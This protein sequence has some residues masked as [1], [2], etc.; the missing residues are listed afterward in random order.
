[1]VL[2]FF[3]IAR[4]DFDARTMCVCVWM[5]GCKRP[6][7]KIALGNLIKRL[8]LWL[9]ME[10]AAVATDEAIDEPNCHITRNGK[11]KNQIVFLGWHPANGRKVRTRKSVIQSNA[12][13]DFSA[14]SQM[15]FSGWPKIAACHNVWVF[16]IKTM[17]LSRMRRM[18][19]WT[20][21][22]KSEPNKWLQAN[23][24]RDWTNCLATPMKRII[25]PKCSQTKPAALKCLIRS[26]CLWLPQRRNGWNVCAITLPTSRLAIFAL[27]SIPQT[28]H[29]TFRTHTQNVKLA[30]FFSSIFMPPHFL[31]DM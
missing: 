6:T 3:P 31:Y 29:N 28:A 15:V 14:T 25:S 20:H 26:I 5:F 11:L 16:G 2:V 24:V 27:H 18:I 17:R 23:H 30:T 7:N 13:H 4:L 19:L 1:M 21:H 8:L 9:I 12:N 10:C 22:R